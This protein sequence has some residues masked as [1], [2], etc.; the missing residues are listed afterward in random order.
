MAA[1]ALVIVFFQR[2]EEKTLQT[3]MIHNQ[4]E[5]YTNMI[6]A[7]IQQW[8]SNV[9]IVLDDL[10]ADVPSDY[11]ELITADSTA[12]KDFFALFPSYLRVTIISPAGNVLFDDT[13]NPQET[14]N[15]KERPEIVQARI[16][17]NGTAIRKSATVQ[18]DFYYYAKAY[19]DYYIRVAIP[20]QIEY[21]NLL[22]SDNYFVYLIIIIFALAFLALLF[23]TERI[24]RSLT[25]L[26]N[27]VVRANETGQFDDADFPDNEIGEL[28]TQIKNTFK[29][30]EESN[31]KAK[32]EREKLLGHFSHSEEGI[33]FFS[34]KRV[35]IYANSRFVQLLN[36]ILDEPTFVIDDRILSSPELGPTK[37]IMGETHLKLIKYNLDKSGNTY[38]V[39]ALRFPDG[40][41]ELVLSDVTKREQDR[42]LKYEMTNSIAHELRTPVSCIRGYIETILSNPELAEEK[43]TY[44]LE[45]SYS[46]LMRLSELIGDVATLTKLEE[47]AELYPKNEVKPAS[48]LRE[49]QDDLEQRLIEEEITIQS[50]LSEELT[51]FA[52]HT[53]LYTIFRNLIE[54]SIKYAGKSSKVEVLSPMEDDDFQYF[55]VA[56]NG[57]GIADKTALGKIF[58][59]FYRVDE[60]RSRSEGGSGLGLSIV[61]NAVLMHGGEIQAKIRPGGGLEIFFSLSR[62]RH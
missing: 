10:P 16:E 52:N 5:E 45:R 33:A 3:R 15:H 37:E 2:K 34:E 12:L 30:L 25:A 18:T 9:E 61:K 40:S 4:M 35:F 44:F 55:I 31:R 60:G 50:Q 23:F 29:I 14:G 21:S 8:N 58:D 59:R 54:N 38:E 56:D 28:S 41:F 24:S 32:E 51:V 17:G 20:Y 48:I 36:S 11:I 62:P 39:R 7:A 49:V 47:A 22:K 27:F 43:K 19:P 57:V 6:D 13:A 46:Q 42:R 26:R 53:L 1:F